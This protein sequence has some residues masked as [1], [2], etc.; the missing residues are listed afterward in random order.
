MSFSSYFFRWRKVPSDQARDRATARQKNGG[1]PTRFRVAPLVTR[2]GRRAWRAYLSALQHR[3]N[4]DSPPS[5]L[6]PQIHRRLH[7]EV[8]S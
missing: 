2:L 1:G 5:I 4:H 7:F 6:V 8:L 3:R